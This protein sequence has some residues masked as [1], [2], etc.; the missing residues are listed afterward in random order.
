ML[1]SVETVHDISWCTITLES[2]L[3]LYGELLK[4]IYNLLEKHFLK[5]SKV[6]EIH[7]AK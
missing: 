7:F 2:T 1:D 5:S 6:S 3:K 4:F